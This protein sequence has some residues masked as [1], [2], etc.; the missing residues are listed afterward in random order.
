M[1]ESNDLRLWQRMSVDSNDILPKLLS[2]ICLVCISLI[3]GSCSL[4]QVQQIPPDAGKWDVVIIGAGAGGLSAGATLTKAGVKTLVL[5]QHDKPGGYMTAFDRG[6]YR[7]EVSLHMM[8]GLGPGGMTR[9]LFERLGIDTRVKPVKLAPLYRLETPESVLDVPAELDLYIKKLQAEFPHEAE[10]IAGLFEEFQNIYDDMADLNN[11]QHRS[12][13]ARIYKYSLFPFYYSSLLRNRNATTAEIVDRHISDIR[14]KA[15][16]LALT[17]FLGLPASKL[18]GPYYAAMLISYYKYGGYHFVGGSQAVS[19]A[20]A[21][22]IEENGGELRLNTLVEKILIEDGKAVGVQ[23]ADGEKILADYVISNADGY[24][25]YL[26]LVGEEHLKPGFVKHVKNMEPGMSAV[27]VYIGADMDLASM[28][29]SDDVTEIFYSRL[30]ESVLASMPGNAIDTIWEKMLAMDLE[31]TVMSIQLY[32][33]ID[34]TCAPEGKSVII[35]TALAPYEWQNR[36]RIDDGYD[37]YSELKEEIGDRMIRMAEDV[38]PGLSN[39]I[40]VKEIGT[41]LTMERYTLNHK[42]SFLGW[43][44]TPEQTMLKRMKQK[45]PIKNLYLAGAWTFPGGGQSICLNSGNLTANMILKK[46]R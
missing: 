19:D 7:F 40:E 44:H 22:V 23:T 1:H 18:I 8:D 4:K 32:S 24:N 17:T 39:V 25:T 13:L 41:P 37:A 2:I 14:L 36:W 6:D 12:R 42:G 10:G 38:I 15:R 11:L 21:A 31:E 35:L 46:I 9:D 30:K 26:K 45:T 33:N 29:I 27:V 16:I 43:A 20:L 28:G 3:I 34:P 5:E